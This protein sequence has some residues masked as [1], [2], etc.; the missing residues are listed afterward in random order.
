MS[1]TI[2]ALEARD[3]PA[4]LEVYNRAAPPGIQP[5][6]TDVPESHRYVAVDPETRRVV[7]FAIV[8]LKEWHSFDL[9][10]SPDRQRQGVGS[11]LWER[12]AQDMA[13]TGASAV[14]PWVREENVPAIGWLTKHGFTPTKLD[15]PVCL[16]PDSANSFALTIWTSSS[17]GKASSY[18]L[19]HASNY[20]IRIAFRN[21]TLY[22]IR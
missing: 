8:P 19:L 5:P 1:I 20:R 6:E 22:T 17:A 12:I 21:C 10:V 2:R 3:Y 13:Q 15:G 14:E 9:V 4:I 11:L 7:G 16:F 18:P